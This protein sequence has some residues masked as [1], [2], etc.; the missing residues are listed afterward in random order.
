MTY[1]TACQRCGRDEIDILD[2]Q[3]R[4]GTELVL[5]VECP[6]CGEYSFSE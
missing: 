4:G 6:D 2:E 3:V 5:T 1:V